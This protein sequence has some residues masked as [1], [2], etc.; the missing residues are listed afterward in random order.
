MNAISATKNL[1]TKTECKLKQCSLLFCGDCQSAS[2]GVSPTS[3][4]GLGKPPIG[5]PIYKKKKLLV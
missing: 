1:H 4:L 2:P 5:Q 3:P